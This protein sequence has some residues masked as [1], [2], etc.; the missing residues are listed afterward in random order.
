MK[1]AVRLLLEG[2]FAREG[3]RAVPHALNTLLSKYIFIYNYRH[4]GAFCN[5]AIR[6]GRKCKRAYIYYAFCNS[7]RWQ[8]Q[9]SLHLLCFWQFGEV[10]NV[11]AIRRGKKCRIA[12]IYCVFFANRRGNK[13]KI[14]YNYCAF[15]NLERWKV[16]NNIYLLCFCNSER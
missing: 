3:E 8:M 15:C 11:I 2:T 14:A 7:E 6:R 5:F 12:Y 16:Q 10:K 4:T 9:N 1:S 13:C